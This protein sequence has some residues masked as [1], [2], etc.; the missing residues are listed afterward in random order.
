MRKALRQKEELYC[1]SLATHSSK[2]QELLPYSHLRI[3][4][5]NCFSD[6]G[7]DFGFNCG[8][9]FL[10]RSGPRE[11]LRW[12]QNLCAGYQ[13]CGHHCSCALAFAAATSRPW[14]ELPLT[15]LREGTAFQT[16]RVP[17]LPFPTGSLDPPVKH[18]A[19]MDQSRIHCFWQ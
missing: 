7:R 17:D 4:K 1:N 13:I 3:Q 11:H 5:R 9:I 15:H 8:H 10:Y 14:I 12:K 16:V 6:N 2:T 18:Q 19:I